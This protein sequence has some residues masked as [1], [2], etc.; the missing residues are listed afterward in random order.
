M[1]PKSL[2]GWWLSVLLLRAEAAGVEEL[3]GVL[4]ESVTFQVKV[5]QSFRGISWTKSDSSKPSTV[6]VVTFGQPCHLVAP[7]PAFAN[8][9][10]VSEDCRG[11]RLSHLERE[12]AGRY[13]AETVLPTAPNTMVESFDLQVSK[14]LLASQLIVTCIPDGGGNGTW[15]LNCSTGTWE[16]GVKFSWTSASQ[17]ED[18]TPGHALISLTSQDRDQNATCTAE[19]L[20]SNTSRTVSLKEVCAEVRPVTEP[21]PENGELPPP[22]PLAP[23]L[24]PP[25]SSPRGPPGGQEAIAVLQAGHL[26]IMKTLRRDFSDTGTVFLHQRLRHHTANKGRTVSS[27]LILGL[28]IPVLLIV[29]VVVYVLKK[30]EIEDP[31]KSDSNLIGGTPKESREKKA[32]PPRKTAKNSQEMPHTIY[33]AVQ[34]PKQD[35]SQ[36]DD[37]KM[38]RKKQRSSP[39][40]KTIYSEISKSQESEDQTIKTIYETV[41]NP[42]P[43][44]TSDFRAFV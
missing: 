3:T 44:K 34:H 5:S 30:K 35:P 22:P 8:R 39:G 18:A 31:I 13:F 32:Q 21:P 37:E 17:S 20:V 27:G 15:Q 25:G 28:T 19:N 9:V 1:S 14:R 12:D 29:V 11:L 10:N 6:A 36:T 2:L 4:G 23:F 33:T 41:K 7:L 16:D 42:P 38:R 24:A 43:V 26:Q 40:E